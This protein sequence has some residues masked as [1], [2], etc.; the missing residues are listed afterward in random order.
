MKTQVPATVELVQSSV[1]Q[2][3]AEEIGGTVT[4]LPTREVSGYEVWS[5]K[6]EGASV[7]I[8]QAMVRSDGGIYKV[9]AATGEGAADNEAV[10]RFISSLSI[11]DQTN[12]QTPK[13]AVAERLERSRREREV[14]RAERA[15]RAAQFNRP[16]SQQPVQQFD[17][18]VDLHKL[19]KSIGGAGALIAI[20]LVVYS[21]M[22]GKKGRS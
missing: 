8:T 1:E 19:S 3:L 16:Q 17:E 21:V 7:A 15:E 11:A 13:D 22:R 4:R 5:M 14:G 2:G 20:G 6:A 9:L 10:T 12:T 18:G